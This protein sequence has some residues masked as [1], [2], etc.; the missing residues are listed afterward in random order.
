[1]SWSKIIINIFVKKMTIISSKMAHNTHATLLLLRL[2]KDYNELPEYLGIDLTDVHQ[3]SN[4][5]D[6]PV[7]IASVRGSIDEVKVLLDNGA[8]IN[9]T[10]EHGYTALHNAVEQGHIKMVEFLLNQGIDTAIKNINHL[11]AKE[12]AQIT[13][14]QEIYNILDD[15]DKKL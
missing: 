11:T 9:A 5:G 2:I 13:N 7:H 10:G 12:L 6:Y 14:N 1:M 4:F 3:K 8:D 15:F